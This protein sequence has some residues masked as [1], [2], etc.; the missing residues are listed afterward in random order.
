MVIDFHVHGKISSKFEFEKNKFLL[1]ID[2]AKKNGLDSIALTEHCH[3]KNFYEGYEF[4][5]YNYKLK[6]D[7]FDIDGFKVFYGTEV[8]TK[9]KLDILFIGN[10]KAVINFREEISKNYN[11]EKFIDIKDLFEIPNINKLF[12]IIA[13]PYRK[14]IVF[15]EL[16]NNVLSKINALEFNSKDLYKNGIDETIESVTKLANKYNLPIVCGSDTHYYKQISTAKN[17]LNKECK[18]IKEIKEEIESNNHIV[19]ISEDL[20]TRVEEAIKMKKVICN[21]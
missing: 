3:A 10:P 17:I 6:E 9:Q 18:N 1:K 13:H 20:L 4:L 21:K 8:T 12:I 5:N 7:Y 15:P 14:H 2:E 19:K 16:Q 11:D